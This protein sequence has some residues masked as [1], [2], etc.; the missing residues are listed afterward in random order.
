[1]FLALPP[2]ESQEG[3]YP[4]LR[5]T[6]WILSCLWTYVDVSDFSLVTPDVAAFQL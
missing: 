3:W 5:V 4:T 1:M 2:P 6:L